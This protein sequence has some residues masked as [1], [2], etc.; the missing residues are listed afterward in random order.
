M[1][2]FEYGPGDVGVL[3]AEEGEPG[4]GDVGR[5]GDGEF[6]LCGRLGELEGLE[7]RVRAGDGAEEGGGVGALGVEGWRGGGEGPVFGVGEDEILG[8][9]KGQQVEWGTVRL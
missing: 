4:E 7:D 9:R 3:G 5:D 1:Q 8:C 2:Q 6:V